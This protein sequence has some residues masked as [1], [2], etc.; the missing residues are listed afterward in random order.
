MGLFRSTEKKPPVRRKKK[1]GAKKKPAARKPARTKASEPQTETRQTRRERRLKRE[2][3]LGM[4][5]AYWSLVLAM[6][7]TIALVALAGYVVFAIP[8]QDVYT[9][10]KR[11]DG[12]IL[13]AENGEVLAES[14]SFL[15]DDVRLSALPDYVPKAL[16]AIEDRRFRSHFGIDVY[17]L[18]RAMYANLSAGRIVQG[19]STITQQLAKNLFLEPRRTLHRKVQEAILALWLEHKYTKDEI[20]QLYLNRVYYGAGAHGIEAAA[21]AYYSKS[22]QDLSLAEAAAMAALL[23]APSRYNPKASKKKSRDR[24]KLVLSNMAEQG[25]ISNKQARLA[26]NNPAAVKA[27]DYVPATQYVVDWVRGL[28]P[29]YTGHKA[30]GLI[31]QTTINSKLQ[32]AS[33]KA[34]RKRLFSLGKKQRASQGALVLM[35]PHGA[36]RAL[37][38]GKS[39]KK[40]QFNRA[41]KAQR[42]PGSAFKPFVYLTAVNAGYRPNT[43]VYDEPFCIG[44]WCPKNYNKRYAGAVS[45]KSSLAHSLNTVAVRLAVEMG[46]RNVADTARAMGI[47]SKISPNASIALGTS[48]VNL[49]ELTTAYAP[50]ANGGDGVFAHVIKRI[51]AKDGR[52]L[53][54]RQ[55]TGPGRVLSGR[56]VGV[57]NAI[58]SEVVTSGTGKRAKVKGQIVAGKTGTTQSYKDAWFIGYSSYY[59]A[60]VWVGN[61]NSKPMRRTTGGGLPALIWNDVMTVAHAGLPAQVLPGSPEADDPGFELPPFE[62]DGEFLRRGR[63]SL[64]GLFKSIFGGAPER[65]H[66]REARQHR[67]EERRRRREERRQWELDNR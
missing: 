25:Y 29:Q 53:Y 55:G 46:P 67:R 20:L 7:G 30:E 40:S 13:L 64:A 62:M 60:G 26:I 31:I 2:K 16:I 44:G 34:L 10:P 66:N 51:V 52:I 22:A 36:V 45:L 56:S 19:G 5:V 6:W 33:E 65:V 14:G 54:E 49:L 61:D 50:F 17:G 9:L 21:R 57:M 48:E 59:V 58:L 38:G 43:T 35:S 4:R 1:T 8:N 41:V 37:V 24:T 3:S 18:G 15:G 27:S 47:R 23:K 63:D 42:Q 11:Q 12:I 28:V 39:Y 32:H